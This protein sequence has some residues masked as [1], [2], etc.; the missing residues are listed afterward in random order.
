MTTDKDKIGELC[1]RL[2][3]AHYDK[4]ADAIV[5]C[6][7]PD[8][9]IFG[10]APPLRT[11]VDRAEVADWLETWDGPILIDAAEQDLAVEGG[12]AWSTALNRMRGTKRDG[13]VEDIWFRTTMCFREDGGDWRIVHDHSSTPFY[14]DGSLRADDDGRCTHIALNRAFDLQFAFGGNVSLH[15]DIRSDNRQCRPAGSSRR[16]VRRLTCFS[17]LEKHSELYAKIDRGRRVC[18]S[19]WFRS[20]GVGLCF[21]LKSPHVRSPDRQ[22]PFH[23]L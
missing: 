21:G 10:L 22:R 19:L 17:F 6:Y 2:G 11:A 8:A 4:D 12:V 13:T 16:P 15:D 23:P 5:G 3:K 9:I 7:A 18:R 1:D 14:M 20:A